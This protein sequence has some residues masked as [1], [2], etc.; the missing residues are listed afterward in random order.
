MN[1]QQPH[2]FAI[3]FNGLFFACVVSFLLALAY[4][5]ISLI[6]HAYP[7]DYNENGMLVTTATI[8]GG[9]NPYSLESQPA[10]VSLYPVFYNILVAPLSRFFGNTLELHRAVAGLF[11]LAGCALCFYLCRKNSV[12]RADSFLAAILWYAGLLFY[13]TPV[14][15]TNSLGLFLFL[16]SITI[17]WVNGFSNRSLAVALVLGILAFYTKQYYVASIGYIALYMF[18]AVSKKRAILFGLAAL[19]T[20]IVTLGLVSYTSPYYLEATF[21][22]VRSSAKIAASDAFVVTQ[23]KEFSQI[24]FPILIILPLALVLQLHSRRAVST[25][26]GRRDRS[27]KF[28][29]F[30]DFD[31]ALL[32]RKVDYIWLCCACSVLIIAL[33]LG[34]N[35]GNS[36]TY[37]F[38]LISPFLIIGT[39]SLMSNL[40]KW[41]WPFRALAILTLYNSYAILPTDFS[42]KEDNWRKVRHEISQADDI[43]G[44]TL[45]LR[46]I[47]DKGSNVYISGGTRY[48]LFGADKPSFLVK[49]DPEHRISEIWERYVQ[50]IHDK[51]RN[52]EFDLLL[53]D[54]WMPLPKSTK[55]SAIDTRTLL[56]EHYTLTAKVSTPLAKRLGGGAFNMQVWKPVRA[57]R[58]VQQPQ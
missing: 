2:K 52:Q 48:F 38:Q 39:F 4:N 45:V 28:A 13:S 50:S 49:N 3:V 7:L 21:F 53:I 1:T 37:L 56:E 6:S 19:L 41:R 20:F 14:A 58:N 31:Q 9:Q 55:D 5:H 51:I 22:A 40:P 30:S 57:N 44:S 16:S 36:L 24:Y 11:I 26:H 18:L 12:A 10:L 17:P 32:L 43:Y 29:I 42:V 33:Y 47:L 35:R 25:E 8:A 54:N 23:L 34:K 46:E 27:K 15:S